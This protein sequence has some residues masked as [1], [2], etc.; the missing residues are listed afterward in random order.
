MREA[1]LSAD[2]PEHL[3]CLYD[4]NLSKFETPVDDRGI[5]D[6]DSMFELAIWTFPETL[7][8]FESTERN[9]HHVYWTESWWVKFAKS[10]TQEE[11]QTIYTFRNSTPQI[12]YVPVPLHAWIEEVMI[13]PPPPSLEVMR[14][15]NSAWAAAMVL[16]RSAHRLDKARDEYDEKKYKTRRVLGY[17]AGITP[18]SQYSLE[19]YRDVLDTEYWLSEL[20]ER[21]YGWRKI[22][23]IQAEVPP[24]HRIVP[25]TRLSDVRAL[26]QRIRNGAIIPKLPEVLLTA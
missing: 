16:L 19:T 7:P 9:K 11:S 15:R 25:V 23:N 12:A 22:G 14:R 13:P 2:L 1:K 4:Y 3:A 8:S 21:L 5:A 17:I 24:E 20:N 10:H 26:R 18:R 6:I